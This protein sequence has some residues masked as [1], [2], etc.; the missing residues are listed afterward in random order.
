LWVRK[1]LHTH[2]KDKRNRKG[3]G[4]G[5]GGDDV[6]QGPTSRIRGNLVGPSIRGKKMEQRE[7]KVRGGGEQKKRNS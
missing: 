3:E 7:G 6:L 4:T 2:W 1:K 5:T